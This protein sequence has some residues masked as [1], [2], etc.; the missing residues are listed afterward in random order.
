[1]QALT[2]YEPVAA[3]HQRIDILMDLISSF[4]WTCFCSLTGSGERGCNRLYH[5][6][7]IPPKAISKKTTGFLSICEVEVVLSI[8][9]TCLVSLY[10]AAGIV[11]AISTL[12]KTG[13]VL[14]A[15]SG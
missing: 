12:L 1:M 8:V 7:Y 9:S 5:L 10:V 6:M 2:L 3:Q 15:T 14:V 4:K 11:Q 13:F